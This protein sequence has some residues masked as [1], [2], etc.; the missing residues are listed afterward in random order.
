[1]FSLSAARRCALTIARRTGEINARQVLVQ[2][3]GLSR[4]TGS[5][6]PIALQRRGMAIQK[7]DKLTVKK[8]IYETT[9][10]PKDVLK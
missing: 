4:V 8:V 10:S 7:G 3:S 9:G 6:T 1:M 5:P 2:L